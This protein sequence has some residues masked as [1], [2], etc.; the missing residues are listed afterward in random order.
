MHAKERCDAKEEEEKLTRLL[1]I[2]TF[3]LKLHGLPAVMA[4]GFAYLQFT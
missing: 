1:L 4:V 2:V 3:W